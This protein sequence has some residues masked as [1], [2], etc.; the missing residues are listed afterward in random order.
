ML[1]RH[2]KYSNVLV[3]MFLVLVVL[4]A[5]LLVPVVMPTVLF[6]IVMAAATQYGGCDRKKKTEI[7]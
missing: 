1:L 7:E 5:M 2:P 3:I 6:V 4:V